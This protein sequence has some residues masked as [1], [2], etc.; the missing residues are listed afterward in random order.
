V[1]EAGT[2]VPGGDEEGRPRE[3]RTV[4][5]AETV[6]Q[7]RRDVEVHDA[8]REDVRIRISVLSARGG[9]PRRHSDRDVFVE[10]EYVLDGTV[11]EFVHDR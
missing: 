2:V 11:G 3:I 4:E 10:T 6:G 9:V 7:S 5:V 8:E 1:L